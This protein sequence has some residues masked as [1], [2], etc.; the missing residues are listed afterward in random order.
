MYLGILKVDTIKQ[1]ETHTKKKKIKPKNN[2]TSQNQALQQKSHHL[3]K[4]L[5]TIVKRNKRRTRRNGQ[6]DK[7][8]DDDAHPKYDALGTVP[9]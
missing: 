8:V 9:R 7:K 4:I 6:I 3:G 2:K 5:R 1:T